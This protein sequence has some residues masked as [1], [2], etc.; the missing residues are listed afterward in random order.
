MANE[1]SI[2]EKTILLFQQGLDFK[3]SGELEL[4]IKVFRIILAVAPNNFPARRALVDTLLELEKYE[5]A[6]FHLRKLIDTDPNPNVQ[7]AYY[8]TLDKVIREHPIK[9][10]VSFSVLP[11]TN[12][13]NGTKNIYFDTEIGQFTINE[14]GRE[15]SGIGLYF[16]ASTSHRWSLGNGQLL[17]LTGSLSGMWYEIESLRRIDGKLS[18]AYRVDESQTHWSVEPYIRKSWYVSS[19]ES[20]SSDVKALGISLNYLRQLSEAYSLGVEGLVE[21]QSYIGKPYM[22]G[23]FRST[24]FKLEHRAS[25]DTLYS[26]NFGVQEHQP[27]A[28]HLAYQ[29]LSLSAG[30]TKSW[31]NSFTTG[32]TVGVGKRDYIQNYTALTFPRM[33]QFYSIGMSVQNSKLKL[34]DTIPRINCTYKR[35]HSNV[36]FY[37]YQTTNCQISLTRN[38]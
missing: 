38:F 2:T 7:D 33:D 24:T 12:I 3:S 17:K 6:E 1:A 22:S 5:A 16:G 31:G 36:A 8:S 21:D 20:S 4:A 34:F 18:L 28:E 25:A 23:P 29:G 27:E 9:Y 10:D 26:F 35:N 30:V 13:N 37:D 11:S 15:S 19:S 14:S 32:I